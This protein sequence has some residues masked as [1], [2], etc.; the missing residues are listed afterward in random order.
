MGNAGSLVTTVVIILCVL[1]LAA[2]TGIYLIQKAR[3]G[4]PARALAA[5]FVCGANLA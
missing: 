1:G 3:A 2:G 4:D 5:A